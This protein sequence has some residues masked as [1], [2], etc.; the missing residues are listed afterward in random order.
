MIKTYH[1]VQQWDRWLGHFLGEVLL[2][3]EQHFL[4]SQFAQQYGTYALLIGVPH[5]HILLDGLPILNHIVL[6]PLINKNKELFYIESAYKELPIA[7]GSVDLVVL[8][9]TLEFLDNPRRLLNE[10]CRIVK[11]EGD[12]IILGFNPY[13]LWGLKKWWVEHKKVPWSANFIPAFKIKD[14]LT[15]A[16]FE[17]IRHDRL[18]FSPPTTKKTLLKY[19]ALVE[20]IGVKCNAFFGGVYA[21]TA[22]AKVIPLTPIKLHWTQK[23]NPLHVSIPG[24]TTMRDIS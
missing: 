1:V 22:K 14:W 21:I 20:K 10:A 13:S 4:S 7:T 6:S 2:K 5:Q 11:P 18:M 8:P 15:L 24:P 17:L 19:L 16:D 23:I 9:H 3:T 12:I